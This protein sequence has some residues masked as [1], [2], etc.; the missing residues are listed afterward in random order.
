MNSTVTHVTAILP[1]SLQVILSSGRTILLNVAEY[2]TSPGY[3]RLID[4]EV[5]AGV[6]IEEWRYGVWP[7]ADSPVYIGLA[8]EGWETRRLRKTA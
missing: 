3:E 7:K 5:F 8:C 2:L 4:P 6:A 1:S